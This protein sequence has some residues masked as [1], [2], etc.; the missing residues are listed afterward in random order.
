MGSNSC[1]WGICRMLSGLP[2]SWV[3]VGSAGIAALAVVI[4]L[5]ALISAA[6]L[7]KRITRLMRG[8][9]SSLEE[10]MAKTHEA[11][12]SA[13]T[14]AGS[15]D[16]RIE[17]LEAKTAQTLNKFGLVRFNPFEDTGADLS[18]SLALLN[19]IGDGITLTSLWARNE[20]RLYAKPIKDRTS[21]YALSQEETRA[22]ELAMSTRLDMGEG[23]SRANA[24]RSS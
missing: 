2:L 3:A 11:A 20:V 15:F 14:M 9:G 8:G 16:A 24:S 12:E 22:I 18:F 6:R 17:L 4:A 7:R 21:R 23:R 5:W 13:R 10:T 19:D 1:D